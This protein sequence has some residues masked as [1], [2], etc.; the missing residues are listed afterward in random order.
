[1]KK[2]LNI[3]LIYFFFLASYFQAQDKIEYT[4]KPKHLVLQSHLHDDNLSGSRKS[5]YST[6]FLSDD[7]WIAVAK[8][9]AGDLKYYEKGTFNNRF[10]QLP[11]KQY[12]ELHHGINISSLEVFPS[13]GTVVF[14]GTKKDNLSGKQSIY[15]YDF[16]TNKIT[17][18]ADSEE[19]QYHLLTDFANGT[20]ILTNDIFPNRYSTD[21]AQIDLVYKGS[22]KRLK[23]SYKAAKL[24]SDGDVILTVNSENMLEIRNIANLELYTSQ[25]VNPGLYTVFN[26]GDLGFILVT[27]MNRRSA[28]GCISESVVIEHKGTLVK[29]GDPLC[30]SFR[31][32]DGEGLI[33]DDIGI[34]LGDR[35]L[36]FQ[37]TEFPKSLSFNKDGSKFF[38]SLTNGQNILYDAAT[39]APLVYTIHPDP[40]N[41]LFYDSENN[42][43]SN[44]D[45]AQYLSVYKNDGEV[46]WLEMEKTHFRPEK[47]L[48]QFGEPNKNYITALEKALSLRK[49]NLFAETKV[50]KTVELTQDPHISP[51]EKGN[52]YLM[53]I[54]VSDYKNSS[55]NLTFADKDALDIMRF[56]GTLSE[57]K[58]AEYNDK[59]Y[60]KVFTVHNA[61]GESVQTMKKYLG[62]YPRIGQ[63]FKISKKDVWVEVNYGKMILWNFNEKKADSLLVPEHFQMPFSLSI[64][65]TYFSEPTGKSFSIRNS[66]NN[67]YSYNTITKT[68]KVYK[69]PFDT[70]GKSFTLIDEYKWMVLEYKHVDSTSLINLTV[71]EGV[72]NKITRKIDF[73]PHRYQERQPDGSS[74]EIHVENHMSYIIPQIR[75][76]SSSGNHLLYS[77]G[78]A[79]FFIDLTQ[80][81]PKP[82][83][84]TPEVMLSNDS[85]ISLASDGTTFN[86]LNIEGIHYKATV[87]DIFGKLLKTHTIEDNDTYI[88]GVS[89][90]DEN[91]K[92]VTMEQA[93]LE[94]NF[95]VS[96]SDKLLNS[97]NPFSFN[98]VFSETL[99]NQKAD[100]KSIE[101]K[102][103]D[104][105]KS[106][107]SNDQIILFMAG[108]GVLDSKNNY[109]FAPHNM[110]FNNPKENGIP[111]E[112][113][114]NSL[115]KSKAKNQLLILDTCHSGNALD[116]QTQSKSNNSHSKSGARGSEAI[117]LTEPKFKVSDIT[118]F[119][120]KDFLSTSGVTIISAASGGDLALEHPGWG[121]G[122]L[123]K[124]FLEMVKKKLYPTLGM[125]ELLDA[126]DLKRPVKLNQTF[127]DELLYEV[128]TATDGKQVPDL[129]EN[130]IDANI[131]V[132]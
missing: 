116:V 108:H 45:P 70:Y 97:S 62:T 93:V 33:A 80:T 131:Y 118:K 78:L 46:S 50:P 88:K 66:D 35:I 24:S 39:L 63:F 65:D 86:I 8:G 17:P 99:I 40:K 128:Q 27:D 72:K 28:E 34:I 71:Y 26:V 121:N 76:V 23:G 119:L 51:T 5:F 6:Y 126:K 42:F 85:K 112:S 114:I 37:E 7:S 3:L 107:N 98:N 25:K 19:G 58:V 117:A 103:S 110:N 115:K 125:T 15:E 105:L 44:I 56:Y 1:M 104:F 130:N 59:F 13:D 82:V 52:L 111:F 127:I 92:W 43:F 94:D 14:T 68:N 29:V 61:G 60:G 11:I 89:S 49:N 38:V 109:Y 100:A 18:L 132:W 54:G 120:F 84:I 57:D 81:N 106:A 4:I 10:A 113:I 95:F 83:K 74:K 64:N 36:R 129:R 69:L 96:E 31:G 122:A 91:F 53:S 20:L 21:L 47:I 102:L 75:S 87:H 30:G 101:A 55:Y 41:H 9:F 73:S 77:E 79:L 2:I 32:V 48:S 124:S 90:Q 22:V 16:I 12:I 123:T 67:I